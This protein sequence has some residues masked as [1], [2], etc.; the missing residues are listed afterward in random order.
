VIGGLVTGLLAL[1]LV[2]GVLFLLRPSTLNPGP[3]PTSS[4]QTVPP[5][6]EFGSNGEMIYFTGFNQRGERIFFSDAPMWLYRHGGSCVDCHGADGRGGE[7]QTM[8]RTLEVPDIRYEA[9]TAEEHGEE[10]MEHEAFTEETIKRAIVEG[11]EPDGEP[12][13]WPMP[14]WSMDEQ[15][16]DDLVAFL[17]TLD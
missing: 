4:A 1:G 8:H 12:L 16:L 13:D 6:E 9:L 17:K 14:R 3:V 2:V 7:V 15:D 11:V 10:G 5:A